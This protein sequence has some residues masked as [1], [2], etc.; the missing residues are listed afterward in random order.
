MTL[1]AFSST[2]R[3]SSCR[4]AC[5]T[6]ALFLFTRTVA[7][8]NA[9]WNKPAECSADGSGE[10]CE[11]SET[12]DGA[13]NGCILVSMSLG[14]SLPASGL[15][16]V[17]LKLLADECSPAT[18]TPAP[19][20]LSFGWSFKKVGPDFTTGGAPR[21][22]MLADDDGTEVPFTFR[23]GESSANPDPGRQEWCTAVLSMVDAEG[24]AMA[25]GLPAFW[26]LHPGDGSVWRFLASDLTDARGELVSATDVRGVVRTK[27]DFGID[28]IRDETGS[29]RQ[30]LAPSRFADV[31]THGFE[32]YTVSIYPISV[33]PA[34]DPISGLYQIPDSA[35]VLV[36]DVERGSS[37]RECLVRIAKG[38]GDV[39]L[40]RYLAK[41]GD[42][43][44]VRPDGL[45]DSKQL[46]YDNAQRTARRIREIHSPDGTLL[47]RTEHGFV[48][49]S[50]GW[51]KT[52]KVEGVSGS[53]RR[54]TTWRYVE[55][56]ANAGL[57]SE[58][59]EPSGTRV[60]FTYDGLRRVIR[61]A[62]PLVDEVVEYSYESVDPSDVVFPSDS[63]PRSVVRYAQGV[64]TE[65]TYYVYATNGVE[66]I[67]RVGEQGAAFGGTN[68]LRT[69]RRYN[70]A[71]PGIS[72][73]R[74]ASVLHED[75]RLDEYGYSLEN[76]VWTE[77]V[78]HLLEEAPVQVPLRTTRS[79]TVRDQLGHLVEK[80]T[81]LYTA[82]V[83][84]LQIQAEWT[85]I[86]RMAYEYDEVGRE[87]RR[88]DLAGRLWTTEWGRSCCGK[89]SET[90]WQGVT[91]AFAYDENDRL[92]V[93][94]KMQPNPI[95]T[96][97]ERDPL[98]RVV[99]TWQTN[100][101][102]GIGI[103]IEKRRYDGLGNICG[104]QDSFGN[105]T[106][107]RHA[108]DGSFVETI[109][110]TGAT[111]TTRYEYGRLSEKILDGI[112]VE[113][114]HYGSNEDGS[115]WIRHITRNSSGDENAE[116]GVFDMFGK[117]TDRW[118]LGHGTPHG[119]VHAIRRYDGKGRIAVESLA[120][121][122]TTDGSRDGAWNVL[123]HR[124]HEYDDREAKILTFDKHIAT[125]NDWL[126]WDWV[127]FNPTGLD[128]G[129]GRFHVLRMPKRKCLE[130]HGAMVLAGGRECRR[131][132]EF[133]RQR[134]I[135]RAFLRR[136]HRRK[137][138]HFRQCFS[139]SPGSE[140]R[141]RDCDRPFHDSRLRLR[142][143]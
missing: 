28:V 16:P 56:G 117:E 85:P 50:W 49:F 100:R 76:G 111:D 122:E 5:T 60:S 141:F 63:R 92:V 123:E 4:F 121:N 129:V 107:L 110:P 116:T 38:G 34:F 139:E 65:R 57:V 86:E 68:V 7:H 138:R 24:W 62:M 120:W 51:A 89:T 104:V 21:N 33:Q 54:E 72:A 101:L 64:E 105:W 118:S 78:V 46:H 20:R 13:G 74:L 95:E 70:A 42:W 18:F 26:D 8:A 133:N 53:E 15:L 99:T 36:V 94:T 112:V 79:V 80:R 132:D 83:A 32:H 135:D 114:Y 97:F 45:E 23:D 113:K 29:I 17:R 108:G 136:L 73:G 81:D 128:N 52:N 131:G 87:I 47:S 115:R 91:T 127:P 137:N 98:G 43:T 3:A 142:T 84:D 14:R 102:S 119:T 69:I 30:I 6:V 55:R 96:H 41:H 61:E 93:L 44:L 124:C 66:I 58:I 82:G 10:D 12:Q 40:Y 134:T 31:V 48:R 22:V 125:G 25:D 143:I 37:D 11:C 88:E 19:L 35:P 77:T 75:G 103:S 140:P 27:A 90:D 130:M 67:E 126:P 9:A 1:H 2:F 109:H 39:R 71:G 106:T 59:T